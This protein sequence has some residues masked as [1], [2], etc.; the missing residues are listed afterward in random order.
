M[1]AASRSRKSASDVKFVIRLGHRFWSIIA[2]SVLALL[3]FLLGPKF[4][5]E[6]PE[7]ETPAFY[8]SSDKDGS[9]DASVLANETIDVPVGDESMQAWNVVAVLRSSMAR[10]FGWIGAGLSWSLKW[11]CVIKGLWQ[12]CVFGYDF[13]CYGE[14]LCEIGLTVLLAARSEKA[15]GWHTA[16]FLIDLA[17][18]S[19][20]LRVVQVGM[21]ERWSQ[22]DDIALWQWVIR[23]ICVAHNSRGLRVLLVGETSRDML[24][25]V[26]LYV[27]IWPQLWVWLSVWGVTAFLNIDCWCYGGLLESVVG[28]SRLVVLAASSTG[29]AYGGLCKWF[30]DWDSAVA[31][32]RAKLQAKAQLERVEQANAL[33]ETLLLTEAREKKKQQKTRRV[34]QPQKKPD[35]DA[36]V[37][38]RSQHNAQVKAADEVEKAKVE[39]AKVAETLLRM[40]EKKT[41]HQKTRRV[42][43]SQKKPNADAEVEARSQHEAEDEAK[44]CK[45]RKESEVKP[46]REV[47]ITRRQASKK[48]ARATAMLK[49]RPAAA[50]EPDSAV[51]SHDGDG[52]EARLVKRG[53]F[54]REFEC[55]IR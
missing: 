49:N 30:S 53:D 18:L 28:L 42:L 20:I 8:P 32:V 38:A 5:W 1:S 31:H 13:A 16:R 51:K 37:E 23:A 21:G 9:H 33:A 48:E 43:Q 14:R 46:K 6:L 24:L 54:P 26:V 35:A 44:A 39:Q 50:G 22:R 15:D 19:S 34:T 25:S 40:G 52:G 12:L 36:E 47:E 3:F 2:M 41:Q 29:Y 7:D 27:L 55:P 10:L 17:A 45:A 11:F 4:Q